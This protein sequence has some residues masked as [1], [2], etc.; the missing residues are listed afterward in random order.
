MSGGITEQPTGARAA[1]FEVRYDLDVEDHVALNM[2]LFNHGAKLPAFPFP[3]G[4][5]FLAAV[6]VGGTA[7]VVLC[8]SFVGPYYF[9]YRGLFVTI[10][11]L[12][13]MVIG[14]VLTDVGGVL[15]R[16]DMAR[17]ARYVRASYEKRVA[18]GDLRPLVRAVVRLDDEGFTEVTTW[19]A[20]QP[21][22]R[23]EER[24][25][26]YAAWWLVDH[27]GV[28]EDHVFL[29][30]AGKGFLIVPR[31]AFADEGGLRAFLDTVDRYRTASRPP[32]G[33][34]EAPQDHVPAGERH[35][36]T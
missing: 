12:A 18:L 25:E 8:L 23:Q 1:T 21:G 6:V 10:A 35:T 7:L 24:K 28:G 4:M 36:P 27:V 20:G 32:H 9:P 30:V 13:V 17:L 14:Y 16:L 19:D 22:F 2:Y 11:V 15:Y 29:R 26:T 31:G 3:S 5:L 34:P 33:R